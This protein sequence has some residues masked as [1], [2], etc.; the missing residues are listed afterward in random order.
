[1]F[2]LKVAHK[3]ILGFGFIA[4][5]LLLASG[6]ALYSFSAVTRSSELVNQQAV[7]VQQKSNQTQIQLLKLAKLSVLGYTAEASDSIEKYQQQFTGGSQLLRQQLAEL[8]SLTQSEQRFTRI[9]NDIDSRYQI[10]AQAVQDMFQ[11]RI[12]SLTSQQAVSAEFKTLEQLIDS[13]GANLLDISYLDLPGGAKQTELIAGSASRIDGQLLGLLNT[14]KEVS[15]I[16][17]LDAAEA[18]QDNI[19]FALSDMQVNI[20]YMANQVARLDTDGLWQAVTSQLAELTTKLQATNS[21]AQLRLNQVQLQ[22]K[23]R[24]Q[25]QLSEQQIE[26]VTQDLDSLQQA[27]DNQFNQLQ[28]NVSDTVSFANSLLHIF[29]CSIFSLITHLA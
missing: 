8:S 4:L 28:Q 23:A 29:V 26:Q 15:A 25:L 7:P 22:V 2:T 17:E 24:N 9:L 11:A 10:Y 5:L 20:D 3:V 21:L 19:S 18:A 6:S 27:A 14:L 12:S 13:I 16:T 1:M